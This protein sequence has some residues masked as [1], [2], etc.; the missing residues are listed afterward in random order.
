[1]QNARERKKEKKRK[2][3]TFQVDLND[4]LRY[5]EDNMI[6]SRSFDSPFH[7]SIA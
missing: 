3:K 1:M 2:E 5:A 6:K 7:H 4:L